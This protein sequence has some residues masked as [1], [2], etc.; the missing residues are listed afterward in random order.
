MQI[1]TKNNKEYVRTDTINLPINI[2]SMQ[3]SADE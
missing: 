3:F 2:I 1:W